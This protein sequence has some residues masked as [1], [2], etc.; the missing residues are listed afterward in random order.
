M[1]EPRPATE[2]E[3]AMALEVMTLTERGGKAASPRDKAE[4]TEPANGV[5]L[6]THRVW[7]EPD[8]TWFVRPV[9]N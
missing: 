7:I 9:S 2:D 3:M 1:T 5:R 6:G 4:L 8:G